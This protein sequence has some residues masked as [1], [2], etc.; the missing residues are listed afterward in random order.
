MRCLEASLALYALFGTEQAASQELSL[1]SFAIGAP[2]T[3]PLTNRASEALCWAL[4]AFAQVNGG[5]VQDSLR[6]GR[7]ALAL[8]KEIKNLWAQILSTVSLM[9]GL[10]EAGEYEEAL[11]LLQHAVA[12]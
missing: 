3:Q 4:L 6:S 9:S 8:S 11:G 12:L 2:S 5:Q 7:R 1:P 10:L